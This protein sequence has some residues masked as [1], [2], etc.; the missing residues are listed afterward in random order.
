MTLKSC[1]VYFPVALTLKKMREGKKKKLTSD[2][3]CWHSFDFDLLSP[4][5]TADKFIAVIAS[6]E[7]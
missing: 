3:H 2:A 4:D 7:R 5:N 6:A 1:T